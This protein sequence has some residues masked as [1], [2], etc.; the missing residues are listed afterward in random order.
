MESGRGHPKG[1]WGYVGW[2][3]GVWGLRGQNQGYLVGLGGWGCVGGGLRGSGWVWGFVGALRIVLRG[4]RRTG[5]AWRGFRGNWGSLSRFGGRF[6]AG[7]GGSGVNVS[8]SVPKLSFPPRAPGRAR[9]HSCPPGPRCAP[10]F[11]QVRGWGAPS[12]PQLPAPRYPS[13]PPRTGV[14]GQGVG[15]SW[16]PLSR[17][18]PL[19]HTG[20]PPWR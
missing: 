7:G 10:T 4:A 3:G 12:P 14:L 1:I 18:A 16:M 5:G 2:P 20:V 6:G 8:P 15:G 13:P 9:P 11:P 19:P 17:C